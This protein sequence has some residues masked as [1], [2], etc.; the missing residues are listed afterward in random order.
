MPLSRANIKPRNRGGTLDGPR[1]IRGCPRENGETVDEAN[2]IAEKQGE[3]GRA[4]KSRCLDHSMNADGRKEPHRER[5]QLGSVVAVE[6][7][8]DRLNPEKD[9][10]QEADRDGGTEDSGFAKD[11]EINVVT[12]R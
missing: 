9:L 7:M 12:I 6:L 4:K 8:F 5:Q 11:L 2:R 10:D 3:A 1:P